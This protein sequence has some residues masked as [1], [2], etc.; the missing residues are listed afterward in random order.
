MNILIVGECGVGKTWVMKQLIK[1]CT[2]Y[3]LG[4]YRFQENEK[5]IIVGKYDG[6]TFEGSDKL[7]MA[8]MKDLDKMLLYIK[9]KKKIAIFEG[10]RFMNKNFIAKAKPHIVKILGDGEKGRKMRGSKQTERQLKTIKTRVANIKSNHNV[11]NSTECL[12]YILNEIK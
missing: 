10:D 12:Q 2:G 11:S 1:D 5:C 3:K 6:S 9:F 8:V 4:M 7:S